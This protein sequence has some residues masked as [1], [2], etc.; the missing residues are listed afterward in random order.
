[1]FLTVLIK[2]NPVKIKVYNI[3][4]FS[5]QVYAFT[6]FKKATFRKRRRNL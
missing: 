3:I 1:M 2:R 6:M 4:F 5:N